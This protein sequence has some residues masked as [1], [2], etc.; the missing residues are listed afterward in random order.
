MY[1][2]TVQILQRRIRRLHDVQGRACMADK[3]LRRSAFF[4]KSERWAWHSRTDRC[5]CKARHSTCEMPR[6][7]NELL[8]V[9]GEGGRDMEWPEIMRWQKW[10]RLGG[11]P[12]DMRART[13]VWRPGSGGW[14]RACGR[15]EPHPQRSPGPGS[16]APVMPEDRRCEGTVGRCSPPS[17]PGPGPAMME[18]M[19]LPVQL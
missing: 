12:G 15:G 19:P 9:C 17:S 8:L 2:K 7:S 11:V 16:D 4:E 5:R 1:S 3:I 10:S 13:H 18:E 14:P 6:R